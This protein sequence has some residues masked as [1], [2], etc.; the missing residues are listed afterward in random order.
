[1][2]PIQ[3]KL[4]KLADTYNIGNMSFRDVAR[5]IGEVHP[6]TVKH[7]LEQLEKKD[8]IEWDKENRVIS[9]KASGVVS[10]IDFTIIPVLG[11]ANCGQANIYADESI[12]GHIKV[13]NKLLRNRKKVFAV[14]AVGHSMNNASIEGR[15]I[16]DGDYVII[17]QNDRN[18]IS[19]DYVLSIIDDV[20]NI[21]KIIIDRNNSQ[22]ALI[23][24]STYKYPAIYIEAS[25]AS[26][27]LING[28]VIQVIKQFK[29]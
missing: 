13:S 8:F 26:K 14:R 18:I 3:Q 9:K 12:E 16:E 24:E 17:D 28:K 29:Q 27:Y 15:N 23:S 11:S 25:E 19:N 7:H 10:N 22:I 4:L 5:I 20:A 1:M 21:K 6:Q 2:H